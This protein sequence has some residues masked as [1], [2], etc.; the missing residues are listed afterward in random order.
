MNAVFY[1]LIRQ[2]RNRIIR[3]FRKPLSAILTVLAV[4]GM[5]SGP[6]LFLFVHYKGMVGEQSRGIVIAVA[7]LFIGFVLLASALSQQGGLFGYAEANLLFTAPFTKRT[8]LLYSTMQTAPASILTA[9][10]MSICLP[11]FIGSVMT[12]PKFIITMLIMALMIFCVY[13]L[14]YYIYI[15]EIAHPGLK[16]RLKKIAWLLVALP[17]LIFGILWAMNGHN[18]KNAALALFDSPFYNAVP[19]FGWAKWAVIS[20]LNG[21]Y[22]TGFL[23]AFLLLLA[24]SCL[25]AKIY[26]SQ[27]VDFYEQAQLDSIRLQK[28]TE[29]IKSGG[30]DA[31]SLS[32]KKVHKTKASFRSGAAAILSRQFLEMRKRGPVVAMRELLMGGIYIAMGLAMGFQ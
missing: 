16:K 13:I 12:A 5:L 22:L 3:L 15:Q 27:N 1:L 20:L 25:L 32:L 24:I 18:A 21:S 10:F 7:Q 4:L 26:Y 8:V 17:V 14:Y 31:S 23:P 30:Y 6:I 2:Y 9:L 29:N 19:V 11:F 28:V